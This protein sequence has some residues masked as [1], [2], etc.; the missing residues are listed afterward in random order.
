[1]TNSWLEDHQ[2]Q[3]FYN[4][5]RASKKCRNKCIS[6]AGDHVKKC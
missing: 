2:Q 1:M 4:G 6:V 3:I 5:I